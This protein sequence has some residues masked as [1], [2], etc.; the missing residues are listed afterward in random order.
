[1]K[2]TMIV[3]LFLV[4]LTG[5]MVKA[6]GE[7]KRPIT[8]NANIVVDIRGLNKAAGDIEDMVSKGE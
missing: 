7:P 4:F 1:M 6:V 2:T 8:I 5:C 3:I